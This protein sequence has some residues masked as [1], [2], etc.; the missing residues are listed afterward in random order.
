VFALRSL[1]SVVPGSNRRLI[2]SEH[3]TKGEQ[4]KTVRR[5]VFAQRYPT[6]QGERGM[7]YYRVPH[8]TMRLGRAELVRIHRRRVES[9]HSDQTRGESICSRLFAFLVPFSVHPLRYNR[10]AAENRENK[11]EKEKRKWTSQ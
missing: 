3:G 2:G 1:L 6:K 7:R 10:P 9:S 4:A 5:T 8:S 11:N